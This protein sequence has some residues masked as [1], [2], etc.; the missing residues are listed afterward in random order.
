M[1][2][3]VAGRGHLQV[4]IDNSGALGFI[5]D[6]YNVKW[7]FDAVGTSRLIYV[8]DSCICAGNY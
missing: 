8:I 5:L 2:L 7:S 1:Q 6:P 3:L 4:E